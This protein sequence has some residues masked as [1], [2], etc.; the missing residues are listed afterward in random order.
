MSL[1]LG[2]EVSKTHAKPSVS[3]PASP[4]GC[5]STSPVPHWSAP[6]FSAMMILDQ[7]SEAISKP[8]IKYFLSVALVSQKYSSNQA[9]A[10]SKN[11]ILLW[12]AWP[13]CLLAE[14]RV[15]DFGLERQS[16]ALREVGGGGLM[17][18]FS[19][20]TE[21]NSAQKN[22]NHGSTVKEG[23]KDKNIIE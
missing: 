6:T 4:S 13:C 18:H 14:W 5:S 11:G 2:F 21:D 20:N 9:E 19:R 16:E 15:W 17:D 22:V 3:L 1:G 23:P 7:A 10:G 8:P 12:Q